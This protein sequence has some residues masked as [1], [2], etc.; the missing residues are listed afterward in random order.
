MLVAPKH[1]DSFVVLELLV[2]LQEISVVD[3]FVSLT[4]FLILFD[5]EKVFV[6]HIVEIL[7]LSFGLSDRLV[8]WFLKLGFQE[9]GATIHREESEIHVFHLELVRASLGRDR[10]V[11][12]RGIEFLFV[13]FLGRL[14]H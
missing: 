12:L 6:I 1:L 4:P 7:F 3:P 13:F 11:F 14:S 9:Q 10:Q 8:D 2:L 5:H